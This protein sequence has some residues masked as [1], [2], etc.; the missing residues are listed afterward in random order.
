MILDVLFFFLNLSSWLTFCLEAPLDRSMDGDQNVG[1]AQVDHTGK[2]HGS[3]V[4]F[5]S[6]NR[7][8]PSGKLA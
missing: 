6:L 8:V 2:Q 7:K 3:V 1:L 4:H 5:N